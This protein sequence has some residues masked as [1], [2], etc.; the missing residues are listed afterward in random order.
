MTSKSPW[1]IL[2]A[3]F[4]MVS[5]GAPK[6]RAKLCAVTKPISRMAMPMM[7]SS[8]ALSQARLRDCRSLL[9]MFWK[10]YSDNA[11]RRPRRRSRLR[12]SSSSSSR[13]GRG[14]PDSVA[15]SMKERL[16]WSISA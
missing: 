11:C 8:P 5:M 15:S 2:S 13:F 7:P 16:A 10:A 14:R 1:P 6:R 4:A 12:L 3:A 9:A